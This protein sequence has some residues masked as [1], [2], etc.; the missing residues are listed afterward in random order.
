MKTE[1]RTRDGVGGPWR[2]G[3]PLLLV[4]FAACGNGTSTVGDGDASPDAEPEA[5]AEDGVGPDEATE[6]EDRADEAGEV[7]GR[8]G[9]HV[10]DPGEECDDGND[11]PGDGCEPD[12]SFGCDGPEEC[13]DGDPCTEDSCVVF[14]EGRAC[15]HA[16]SPGTACDDGD[17]CTHTDRCDADGGCAGTAYACTPGPCESASACDGAG[18]CTATPAPAGQPCD[19]G[20]PC[21]TP[22]TCDGAGTCVPGIAVCSCPGGTDAE[23]AA[24]ED[25][26]ACNGTLRCVEHVC[27]IDP[28]TVVTCPA[29]PP[30]GAY[31]CDPADGTCDL[32][33]LPEGSGCSDGTYCNGAETCDGAGACRPGAPPCPVTGCVGGCDET[34]RVC[35]PAAAGTV[36]RPAV[37]P[38]DAAEE[39]SGASLACP[40]DLPTPAG[41]ACDDGDPCTSEDAC[42][43]AGTCVGRLVPP[44]RLYVLFLEPSAP[45]GSGRWGALRLAARNAADVA[46]NV[47]SLATGLYDGSSYSYGSLEI[48]VDPAGR[49]HVAYMA[50][51]A[52]ELRYTRWDG[53]AW[54][55]AD[56]TAGHDVVDTD[57]FTYNARHFLAL[58]GDVPHLVYR[59]STNLKY[60]RW[61]STGW[62]GEVALGLYPPTGQPN[63]GGGP[64]L[65]L[66]AGGRPHVAHHDHHIYRLHY[67]RFDGA[68]W[69]NEELTGT[70]TMVGEYKSIALDR[71]GR[72]HIA[73]Q[74]GYTRWDGSAW[75]NADGTPGYD[76]F[77]AS[78]IS[79]GFS[80]TGTVL[81]GAHVD[82]SLVLY[83]RPI[84]GGAWDAGTVVGPNASMVDFVG[85]RVCGVHVALLRSVSG[86]GSE[87]AHLSEASDGSWT[88]ETV[89][90]VPAGGR[91]VHPTMAV[92]P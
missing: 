61:T 8:C 73:C 66:D 35:T 28:A 9:D 71:L 70:P 43:D 59:Q 79:A 33:L 78:F 46:W 56:G 38:C 30:C 52:R 74:L 14:G 90:P 27:A 51:A 20:D 68:A 13:D 44:E 31:A 40:V 6:V 41:G 36:C 47:E 65:T 92:W 19:D 83:R 37:G 5:E 45:A 29:D 42:D 24:F 80:P 12:C 39:C 21:T 3:P 15:A 82:G 75:V 62:V 2:F 57:V 23:C 26:D 50:F 89:Y 48:A 88:A 16:P 91:V 22:D 81:L 11:A 10:L 55:R 4:A 34:A 17:P 18:N 64:A 7:A 77:D 58:R 85:D 63:P 72:P 86:G 53:T 54:V 69:L 49:P 32:V 87:V 84:D 60:Y 67:A 76:P 25:G 1:R